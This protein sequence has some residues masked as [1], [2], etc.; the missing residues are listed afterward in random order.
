MIHEVHKLFYY[1]EIN[2]ALQIHFIN[3]LKREPKFNFMHCKH[4]ISLLMDGELF[5]NIFSTFLFWILDLHLFLCN[6]KRIKLI[7]CLGCCSTFIMI[8]DKTY[9]QVSKFHSN[10]MYSF[11]RWAIYKILP[12]VLN[13]YDW[14][15]QHYIHIVSHNLNYIYEVLNKF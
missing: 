2:L 15:H 3:K 10:N 7:S 13:D 6:R 9:L 5:Q 1:L 4:M 8:H 14:L 11:Y 12:Y